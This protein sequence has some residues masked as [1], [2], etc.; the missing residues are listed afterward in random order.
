MSA[1][2]SAPQEPSH[3]PTERIVRPGFQDVFVASPLSDGHTW[4]LQRRFRYTRPHD[5]ELGRITVPNRF[6]T[7]FASVPSLLTATFP[8]WGRYGP[9]AVLHDWLYWEQK[10]DYDRKKAD[11][12]FREAMKDLGVNAVVRFLFYSAVR[13]FGAWAWRENQA[14]KAQG[15]TRMRPPGSAW[16][17]P[18][19]FRRFRLTS[20]TTW[21]RVMAPEKQTEAV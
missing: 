1:P 6:E 20:P 19:T 9:A 10:T 3:P 15:V 12:V 7:D 4:Y 21:D 17:G 18:P 11:A 5:S 16:P 13:I 8:R 14:L 2:L